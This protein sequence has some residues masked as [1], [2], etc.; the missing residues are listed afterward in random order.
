MRTIKPCM[1][2]FNQYFKNGNSR[3]ISGVGG[4]DE[5]YD[6]TVCEFEEAEGKPFRFLQ[7]A[8]LLHKMP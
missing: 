1:N 6:I 3:N 2:I 4:D 5:L 7:C 8:K